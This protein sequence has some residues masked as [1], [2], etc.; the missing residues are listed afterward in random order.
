MMKK[1]CRESVSLQLSD[2]KMKFIKL[3]FFS[4]LT[5]LL[6]LIF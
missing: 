4:K 5:T 6:Q 2:R 1:A 3:L